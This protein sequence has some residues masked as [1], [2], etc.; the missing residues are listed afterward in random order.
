MSDKIPQ[1]SSVLL[2]PRSAALSRNINVRLLLFQV[3]SRK[4]DTNC[5]DQKPKQLDYFSI[6]VV[7]RCRTFVP[8]EI[9]GKPSQVKVDAESVYSYVREFIQQSIPNLANLPIDAAV[10][11]VN[12]SRIYK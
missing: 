10:C 9:R 3:V 4:V 8:V 2:S 1:E 6:P 11:V 5:A 7:R 12:G